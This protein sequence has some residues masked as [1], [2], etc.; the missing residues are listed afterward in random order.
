MDKFSSSVIDQ[1][2]DVFT[3]AQLVGLN[4]HMVSKFVRVSVA[5]NL[6]SISDILAVIAC[7]CFVGRRLLHTPLCLLFQHPHST[8]CES[9]TLQHAPCG[10]RF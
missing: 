2:K 1:H 4:D 7:G 10:R 5:I 9:C 6:H 8:M 3:N